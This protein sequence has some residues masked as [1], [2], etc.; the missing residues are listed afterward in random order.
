[1]GF[2]RISLA[3]LVTLVVASVGGAAGTGDAAPIH[4]RPDCNPAG[5]L[6]SQAPDGQV[7]A[8][9]RVGDIA[10]GPHTISLQDLLEFGP[11]LRVGPPPG[12]KRG[13]RPAP[14]PSEPA[15]SLSVSPSSGGPG[16][17]VTVTGRLSHPFHPRDS[18]PN[19]CW[20]GCQDGLTYGDPPVR[21]TSPRSFRTRMIVPAAPWI[22][23]GSARVAPL[24][25]GPG[26]T[27]PITPVTV[28]AG[29]L[30]WLT[31]PADD[32][33]AA[34]TVNRLALSALAC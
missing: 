3:G 19:L 29:G 12:V 24:V 1:M 4:A 8:C 26:G 22:E 25:S 21:W 2:S 31:G 13:V 10:P 6:L 32:P 18:H 17:V 14:P 20:D 9:L 33:D 30:W 16:T 7:N 27:T 15:V 34:P 5:V 11:P 23:G 28:I